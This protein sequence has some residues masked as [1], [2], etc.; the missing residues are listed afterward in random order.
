MQRSSRLTSFLVVAL[1][2][3]NLIGLVYISRMRGEIAELRS[4]VSAQAGLREEVQQLRDEMTAL[5]EGMEWIT[6]VSISVG[7]PSDEAVRLIAT[8]QVKDFVEGSS[9]TF[10]WKGSKDVGFREVEAER[11]GAGRFQARVEEPLSIMPE[12]NVSRGSGNGSGKHEAPVQIVFLRPVQCEYYV[13][14]KTGDSVKT[15]DARAIDISKLYRG[16]V[17][18]V[19]VSV[20]DDSKKVT[21]QVAETPDQYSK[22]AFRLQSAGLEGYSGSSKVLDLALTKKETSGAGSDSEDIPVFG[23]EMSRPASAMTHLWLNLSYSGGKSA[24]IELSPS[25]LQ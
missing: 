17:Y 7:D 8:W 21:V 22:P 18:G 19:N 24:R 15:A 23:T 3:A 16:L 13:S 5:R 1:I 14:V 20:T 25:I 4:A 11:L 2:A 6:P 9:V 12:V 10:H